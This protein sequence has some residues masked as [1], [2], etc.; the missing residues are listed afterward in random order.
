MKNI[1]VVLVALIFSG[2][3]SIE[4]PDH[5]VSDT[6][7]AGKNAYYS[8]KDNFTGKPTVEKKTFSYKYVVPDGESIGDSSGKCIDSAVESARKSLDI[9]SVNV[10]ETI[11]SS[12]VEGEHS[13]INCKIVVGQG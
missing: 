1:P 13:V 12:A 6:I 10:E 8:V 7:Q 5:L 2:C 4:A 11:I 3:V 9:Y